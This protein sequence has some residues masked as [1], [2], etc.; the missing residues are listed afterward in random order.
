MAA[1]TSLPRATPAAMQS[2]TH[3]DRYRS[4][5]VRR[6]SSMTGRG[7]TAVFI[8]TSLPAKSNDLFRFDRLRPGAALPK[9]ESQQ[10]LQRLRIHGI[11]QK[12]ALPLH[13][14]DPFVF[15]LFEVMGE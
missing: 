7:A 2:A 13:V 14:D 6:L 10:F 15:Q 1:G 3:S 5:K 12:T 8:M 4:K 9:Q 11:A